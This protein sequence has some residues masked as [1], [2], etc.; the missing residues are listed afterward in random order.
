MEGAELTGMTQLMPGV[1]WTDKGRAAVRDNKKL[2]VKSR[3]ISARDLSRSLD[4]LDEAFTTF[5]ENLDV[6][7]TFKL[8]VAFGLVTAKQAVHRRAW[9][10]AGKYYT[11][12]NGLLIVLPFTKGTL[13]IRTVTDPT[14]GQQSVHSTHWTPCHTTAH[15]EHSTQTK[16]KPTHGE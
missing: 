1:Y 10:T 3:G 4:E 8:N 12:S 2:K 16:N 11:T 13:A 14:S 6:W 15:S 7:P 9:N 5:A